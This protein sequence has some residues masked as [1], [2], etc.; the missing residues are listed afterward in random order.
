[1]MN[2]KRYVALLA[3]SAM[4]L[5]AACGGMVSGVDVI[6]YIG[7][8][9]QEI[10]EMLGQPARPD[11]HPTAAQMA[12][13]QNIRAQKHSRKITIRVFTKEKSSLPNPLKTLILQFS[14][15]GICFQVGGA[16]TPFDTPES[17]LNAVGL[18][19]LDIELISQDELG[20][21]YQAPPFKLVEVYRPTD[22]VKGYDYFSISVGEKPT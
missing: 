3:A 4:V 15:T 19:H 8:N 22:W 18:G 1:M 17:L 13:L 20:F 11:E 12:Q 16:T 5:L 21:N 10:R 6:Q 2:A 7:K 9:E 14:E